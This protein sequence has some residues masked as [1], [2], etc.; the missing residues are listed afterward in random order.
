M[1]ETTVTYQP[2]FM[3]H[4]VMAGSVKPVTL[5]I[6]E[7]SINEHKLALKNAEKP[8]TPFKPRDWGEC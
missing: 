1:Q 7:M 6:P 3:N 4:A 2:K 8:V 5:Y